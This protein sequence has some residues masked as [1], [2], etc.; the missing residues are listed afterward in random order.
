MPT[1]L[2]VKREQYHMPMIEL[3]IHG[4]KRVFIIDTGAEFSVMC[5]ELCQELEV[6]GHSMAY[7]IGGS[8]KH[9]RYKV[10]FNVFGKTL[11]EISSFDALPNGADGILGQDLLMQFS[12]VIFDNKNGRVRFIP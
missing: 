7:G 3:G 9:N 12:E 4:R 2:L 6:V 10:L 5:L 8:I 11:T 1:V